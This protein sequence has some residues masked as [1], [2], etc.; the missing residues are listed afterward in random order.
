[1]VA[2]GRVRRVCSIVRRMVGKSDS[3][4]PV[5]PGPPGNR[6]S[7]EDAAGE[8][9]ADAPGGVAGGVQGG[10]DEPVH[11]DYIAV[12]EEVVDVAVPCRP[13]GRRAQGAP[14]GKQIG[15]GGAGVEVSVLAEVVELVGPDGR[16]VGMGGDGRA[17]GVADLGDALNVV[18]V[19]VGEHD[20]FDV[21]VGHGIEDRGG[22]VAGVDEDRASTG[23]RRD[24]VAVGV[25]WS[26]DDATQQEPGA[27]V[28]ELGPVGFDHRR[29]RG[30]SG[31]S[32]W[33]ARTLASERV[34]A[35]R[36][37]WSR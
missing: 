35:A 24:D 11:V 26:D 32:A 30:R 15:G 31:W 37:S 6:V 33:A 16:V 36:S 28:D 12:V 21:D 5:S 23:D 3:G 18:E 14:G 13:V 19:G 20:E 17:E 7:P 29:R 8:M 25:E 27:I 9:E 4:G 34:R 2:G 22:V 1:M 10:D